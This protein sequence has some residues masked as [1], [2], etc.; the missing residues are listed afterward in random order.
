MISD[1]NSEENIDRDVRLDVR[2]DGDEKKTG[3]LGCFK[4]SEQ[5]GS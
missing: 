2:D 3:T 1:G 4:Y 5:G